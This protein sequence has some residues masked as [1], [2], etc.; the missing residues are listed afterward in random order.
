MEGC[1]GGCVE[2][3]GAE[4]RVWGGRVQRRGVGWKGAEGVWGW[5][6]QRMMWGGRV[7]RS[8]AG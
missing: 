1:R 2:W 3:M 8:G 7:K 5:R 4:E 6:V